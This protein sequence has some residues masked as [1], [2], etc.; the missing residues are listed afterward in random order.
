MLIKKTADIRY[1]EVTPKS[2]Y[3]NRR[4]FLAAVPAALLAGRALAGTKLPNLAKSPF[5]TTEKQNTYDQ[6]THYNNFYEFGTQKDQPSKYATNFKTEPWNVSI[7]GQVDKP[8]KFSMDEI[9]KL[10]PLE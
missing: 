7:E 4:K 1:S 5:S 8:R 10:A 6:V 3:L 9:L 2:V